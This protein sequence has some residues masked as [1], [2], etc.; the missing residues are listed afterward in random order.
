MGVD[1]QIVTLQQDEAL[2]G[3]LEVRQGEGLSILHYKSQV[4]DSKNVP[5]RLFPGVGE[6][7]KRASRFENCSP[8]LPPP[9]LLLGF[10]WN[11]STEL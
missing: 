10:S 2:L 3:D 1:W 6:K 8:L 7:E 9:Q 4:R 5:K 11:L